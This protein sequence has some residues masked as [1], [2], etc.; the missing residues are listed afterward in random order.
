M[1]KPNKQQAKEEVVVGQKNRF[2]ALDDFSSDSDSDES[3]IIEAPP[4]VLVE[5]KQPVQEKQEYREREFTIVQKRGRQITTDKEGWTS[6]QWNKP[7]FIDS[8]TES[9][10]SETQIKK[11][12]EEEAMESVGPDYASDED[13]PPIIPAPADPFPSLLN[14]GSINTVAWAEKIKQSLEKA[15]TNRKPP[16]I[17]ATEDFVASL[18]K[19]SFF[20]KQNH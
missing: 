6:V 12:L 13:I 7:Q 4:V 19:V 17:K 9:V 14:R 16:G 3:V 15:E 20:G 2:A 5:K 8:E 10:E 18:G 11:E 1:P